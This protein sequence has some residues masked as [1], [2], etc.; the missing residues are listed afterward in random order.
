MLE[1]INRELD[2]LQL[3]YE[4]GTWTG[5]DTEL[6]FTGEYSEVP[7]ERE[8]GEYR[9]RFTLVGH[10]RAGILPLELWRGRIRK[11]FAHGKRNI[12]E[13][14]TALSAWYA[15][16]LVVPTGVEELT[17]IEIYL[18]IKEWRND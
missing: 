15:G 9:S 11:S 14:G 5:E 3:P 7:D 12:T 1:F 4:F 8:G 6:Y 17:R 10:S 2:A 16:S 18:D 13:E